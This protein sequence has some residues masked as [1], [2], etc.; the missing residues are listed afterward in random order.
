MYNWKNEKPFFETDPITGHLYSAWR[1]HCKFGYDLVRNL[2]PGKLVELGTYYGASFFSFCQGVKDE[3]L[4][5][6]CYAVDTWIGDKHSGFFTG[7]IYDS[8]HA[9]GEQ[10][11]PGIANLLRMTFDEA[12]E[13]FEDN[14]IDLLHID[15]LHTYEAV[16]HDYELWLPKLADNGVVLFHDI[17]VHMDDFGVYQLWDELQEVYPAAQFEHS[18]GLGILMPKGCPPVMA[19]MLSEW[20]KIKPLYT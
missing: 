12:I 1:G 4:D 6:N 15:G 10:F 16:K 8:V 2:K 11:Y 9:L 5:T 20:D 19:H 13:K 7:T 17:T 3:G 14:S 18:H